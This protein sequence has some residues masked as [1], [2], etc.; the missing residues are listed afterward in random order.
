[1]LAGGQMAYGQNRTAGSIEGL[2]VDSTGGALPG[3][4][5]TA[6]SPALQIRQV[7]AVT[8]GEGRYR[9]VDLSPGIY[10]VRFELPGFQPFVRQDLQLDAG[11]AARVSATL[12]IGTL[13]EAIVVTGES[14]VVDATNTGGGKT[15]P[16]SM[17]T[18]ELPGNKTLADL[19]SLT[20]GLTNTAGENP[21][22]LGLQ[23]RP[24]FAA[25]GLASGNTNTTVMI[26]GFQVIANNPLPDVGA[27]NQTDIKT[28][29]N[30]ADVRE[31]GIAMNLVIKSGGNQFHGGASQS[32]MKQPKSNIDD[33]LRKRHLAV[34][35]Q[36]R[37]FADAGAD[38]G[39]RIVPDKLWFYG[40]FRYRRAQQTQ[41]GLVRNAGP[42]GR[43]L[44]GDEPAA[45]P[46]LEGTNLAGK[47]S[48]QFNT[49]YSVSGY[50]SRDETT[51]EAEI[52]IAP[53]GAATDFA[54]TAFEATNP[55]DWKP[56]VRKGEFRG[57]LTSRTFFDVN[58]GKSG[59]VLVYENQPEAA[60][61]PTTYDR[62]NL[63]L[64]GANI[65]HISRFN[66]WIASANLSYLPESFFGGRHEFKMGYYL[67]MRDNASWRQVSSAGDY[68]LMFD[69]GVPQEVE[70]RN[71][72]VTPTEWDNTYSVFLSDQWRIGS[73]VTLNLGL[74]WDGQ[75]SYVPEQSRVAGAFFPAATFPRVE[76]LR[77][78]HVAPRAGLAWDVSGTGRSVFKLT[79]GWFN[80]EAGLAG[81][82][83]KN[84]SFTTRF[85]WRDL[86][87][88]RDFDAGEANLDPNG[89]DFVSTTSAAN[90]ILNPDLKLAHVQEISATMEH[91]LTPGTAIRALYLYR[92]FGDQSATVNVLRPYS[93]FTIPITRQDPGPDGAIG[94]SDDG[95][96]ITF[97][98]YEP[99]Y[100]GS[101]FV[102]NKTV[103]RPEGRDDWSQ[104][105]EGGIAK[106]LSK[107]WSMAAAYTA[108]KNHTWTVAVPTSP[109]DNFFPLNEQ[110]RWSAK[111]NGNVTLPGD[112]GLG[113]IG[114]I[115]SAPTGTRTYVFRATDP[116]GGTPLRQLTS[117]NLR[118]EEQGSQKE[119]AYALLN[120][121]AGKKFTVARHP[122][123]VSLDALNIINSN[124]VKEASYVS[125]PTFR[126]V[127]NIVPPR[128]L[129]LGIQYQF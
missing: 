52:Q 96:R 125:G 26:D 7:A 79:Y 2:V 113:L 68:S 46:T 50:V 20:P 31:P 88:N 61:K 77:Q 13:A 58:V 126:D 4:T 17:I 97:Y 117:V 10:E 15:I 21:G 53:F 107:L 93:A 3:V 109:N 59:Y 124:A 38:L 16:T 87:G 74:R 98:D 84:G 81:D 85:R 116:Q 11:F 60:G 105:I 127:L 103:N 92:R 42:D 56:Y 108:T 47:V 22:S 48:Y 12:A 118:L 49:R 51:N 94:T 44:T 24:R 25:Y 62:S 120:V 41:P 19:V 75:H 90:N 122:L 102:G 111:L 18:T 39:G 43:Y 72:P 112:I 83:N 64:T 57:S 34:G 35:P 115:L 121:R 6:S 101:A 123:Q 5:V 45:Y 69:A 14:P 114:E 104:S 27:T 100:R 40:A 91:E 99:A 65:P 129:R 8:D 95:G 71:A 80:P 37:Y 1:M 32:F 82:F 67:G 76:V 106:R 33:E 66:F 55:F 30:G 54:H 128:Q 119:K 28:F 70:I 9:I 89:P 36:Q 78:S 86:N 73:R 63:M 29:G 23:G 110:W